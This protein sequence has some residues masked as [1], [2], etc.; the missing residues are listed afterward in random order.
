MSHKLAFIFLFFTIA[1]FNLSA[2][3]NP[4][5]ISANS[6]GEY[7]PGS[8][9]PIATNVSITDPDVGDTTLDVVVIQISEGYSV[10]QDLLALSVVQPN[11]TSSWN[12]LLGELTLTGTASFAE[13][14]TA[15]EAVTYQTTQTIFN[16]D[17][18]FSINLGDA[19][20]LPSTGH[21]YFYVP[22]LGITWSNAKTQAET[23]T[24]FGLQGYLATIT[25]SEES[26]LAG[27]QSP[28]AGWIGAT[29]AETEN[30]WRWVT[31]PEAGTI[32]WIGVSNGSPQ[33]GMFNFWN[34]NEPNNFGGNEDYA[35]IT[36]PSIGQPGSWNDLPVTGDM[37][38][39]SPYHPK[40]Y[41]VEFG[42]L[43]GDPIINLSTST[44]MAM[45]RLLTI[46]ESN[47]CGDGIVDLSVTTN[48]DSVL[49]FENE[50][51]TAVLNNG[52]TFSPNITAT[53]TYW[54]MPVF[55]GCTTGERTQ[56]VATLNPLPEA[57][58]ITIFQCDDSVVNDGLTLFNINTYFT[59]ISG[60]TTTNRNIDY[61]LDA[62]LTQSINGDNYSNISNP[63]TIF[64]RVTN[65][66]TN[67]ETVSQVTLEVN[68]NTVNNATL[69]TCDEDDNDGF[70][71]FNLSLANPQILNGLP[72][73]LTTAFYAT[74]NDALLENNLLDINYS[75][76]I[77]FNQTIYARVLEANNCYGIAEINLVVNSLPNVDE[78]ET[79]FYCLN[80]FPSTIT[81]SVGFTDPDYNYMWSTGE[82]TETIEVNEVGIYTVE[83]INATTLCSVI[84]T[85]TV[86]ASNIATID[87]VVIVDITQNN[88]ITVNVSGEGVYQYALNN[89]TG[90]YQE[91]NNFTDLTAGIYTV[92]VRDIKN[93]CGIVSQEV[94]VLGYPSFFT[95]NGD[96]FNETWKIKGISPNFQA[97]FRVNIYN[98]YGK[99]LYT[100][101]DPSDS[102]DGTYNG[103]KLPTSDYW[104]TAFLNRG[105]YFKGHFTL[106]SN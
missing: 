90:P 18:F 2:Q 37:D 93:N 15:I 87:S 13:Y 80:S 56:V 52:V 62:A 54:V 70:S 21:Y 68:A 106:K 1:V 73:G 26:Q 67:C 48:A 84:K 28:G 103:V 41:L 47:R 9:I 14:E 69:A 39:S 72:A 31:G 11:I 4:P 64:A 63:Q 91:E 55:N 20:Y 6:G 42:G 86:E 5:S 24:F 36:D 45:P 81:L 105:K 25:T 78:D 17:K 60:G 22:S 65:T 30:T 61:F 77:A 96:G 101:D 57:N 51:T 16:E 66:I 49:W 43:P 33:N 3:D 19:N 35:H 89:I 44:S 7:C 92:Y 98:R 12:T 34:S 40:G 58:N 85:I 76:T 27:E 46:N 88:M 95:P 102:W 104:F 82:I 74:Y 10:G 100:F 94:Y 23:Q 29:D 8:M 71:I 97:A 99:L 59:D 32:F 83:V 79:I 50:T 75:N 38:A 53:T